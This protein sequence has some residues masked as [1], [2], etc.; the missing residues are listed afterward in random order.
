M[1]SFLLLIPLVILMIIFFLLFSPNQRR[2]ILADMGS[3]RGWEAKAV[4]MRRPG[5]GRELHCRGEN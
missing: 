2:I 5:V 1:S 4:A 3:A